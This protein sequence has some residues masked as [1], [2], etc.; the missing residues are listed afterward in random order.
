MIPVCLSARCQ[1]AVIGELFCYPVIGHSLKEHTV[2]SVDGNGLFWSYYKGS[3]KT[4]VVAKKSL[5]WNSDLT[6]SKSL[7]LAPCTVL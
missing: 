7:S 6:V 1:N 2:N 3:G 4:T 5:E